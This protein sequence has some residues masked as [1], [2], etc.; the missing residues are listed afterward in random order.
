MGSRVLVVDDQADLR[1]LLGIHLAVDGHEV[2]GEATDLAAAVS[3]AA[4][5]APDVVIVDQEL[6][7]GLG[8]G[9]VPALRAAVPG[10]R[11]LVYSADPAVRELAARAGA[12]GFVLK[13]APLAELSDLLGP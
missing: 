3:Q 5:L 6:P 1:L 8:T 13:G 11:I 4:M 7:D 10:V 9:A 12:D 2:V